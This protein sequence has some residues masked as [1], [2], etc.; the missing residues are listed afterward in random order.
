MTAPRLELKVGEVV[1]DFTLVA[2]NRPG[3]ISIADYR[4][5]AAV[6][7]GIFRGLY[8]S[9]CRRQILLLGSAQHALRE[10]GI[11]VLAIVAT[12]AERAQMFLKHR[13]APVPVLA[14]PDAVVAAAFGVPRMIIGP[15]GSGPRAWPETTMEQV[16]AVM[17]HDTDDPSRPPRLA[18]EIAAERRRKDGYEMLPADIEGTEK[19][20]PQLTCHVLVDRGGVVRW[21][22]VEAQDGVADLFKSL[23]PAD[24]LTATSALNGS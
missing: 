11:E 10:R 1:P 7:L 2:A 5:K 13:P 3:S 22:H 23:S 8:C 4:G 16:L 18:S 12:P 19:H 14:D 9:F 6:L 21:T 20:G 15:A 24:L 17:V